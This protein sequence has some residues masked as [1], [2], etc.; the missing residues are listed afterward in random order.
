MIVQSETLKE[1]VQELEIVSGATHG[2]VSLGP[3]GLEMTAVGH[4]GE[5]VVSIPSKGRHV[6]SFETHAAATVTP[7]KPRSYPLQ[8]LLASMRGLDIAQE[9]CITINTAG[10]MAIQHQVVDPSVGD[11]NPNFVDFILCCME[12]DDD[13]DGQSADKADEGDEEEAPSPQR[14]TRPSRR[15]WRNAQH[16]AQGRDGPVSDMQARGHRESDNDDDDDDDSSDEGDGGRSARSSLPLFGSLVNSTATSLTASSPRDDESA[17]LHDGDGDEESPGT[18]WSNE[19]KRRRMYRTFAGSKPQERPQEANPASEST[20]TRRRNL[21]AQHGSD[22]GGESEDDNGFKSTDLLDNDDGE[23]EDG[24][25]DV[26]ASQPLDVTE[27]ASSP[28][29]QGRRLPSRWGERRN[30]D[31]DDDCSSPELAYGRQDQL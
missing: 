5:C 21:H 1:M 22:G 9:T 10:M 8:S 26:G 4:L 30:R 11:G 18:R 31:R 16:A 20:R 3:G 12:E 27:V 17:N 24:A 23:D 7:S 14:R 6:L 25:N 29:Q 28:E 13:E 19:H 2:T 15:T